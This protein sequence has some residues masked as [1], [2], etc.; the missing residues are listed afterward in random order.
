MFK[1]SEFGLTMAS[2]DAQPCLP[3][4]NILLYI[5]RIY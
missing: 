2:E 1:K 5:I 3:S 4:S